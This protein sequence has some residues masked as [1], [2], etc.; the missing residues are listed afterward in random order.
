MTSGTLS[1][2]PMHLSQQTPKDY[3]NIRY[4]CHY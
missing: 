2:L 3:I 1:D 4:F